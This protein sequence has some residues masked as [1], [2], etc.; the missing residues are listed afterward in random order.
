VR[1]FDWLLVIDGTFNINKDRLPLL[2]AVGVL[3]C[4]KTLPACFS[5]YL[6]ESTESFAFVWDSLKEECF[7][8]DGNLPA[9]SYLRILLGGQAIL[10]FRRCSLM[11]SLIA[12]IGTLSKR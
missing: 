7:K 10:Q 9:L 6:S 1:L 12:V 5:Y 11:R 4:G 8:P 3:N 2:I